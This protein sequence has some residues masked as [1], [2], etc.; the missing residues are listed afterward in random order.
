M[1]DAVADDG[2]SEALVCGDVRLFAAG[3]RGRGNR[4]AAVVVAAAIDVID[5]AVPVGTPQPS[6]CP[7]ATR[8]VDRLLA[9]QP[10]MGL[11]EMP[12]P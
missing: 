8:P 11:Q 9:Y 4:A 5:D 1:D 10:S 7:T 12:R 6:V 2:G 3:T